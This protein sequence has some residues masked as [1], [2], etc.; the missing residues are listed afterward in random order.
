MKIDLHL[1]STA[2][3]GTLSPSALTWAARAGGLDVIALTDHDTCAGV[4]EALASLPANL[5]LVPGIELSTTV[6]ANELHILG[7]FIDH[8]NEA[9]VRHATKAAERRADR[10]RR[11]LELLKKYNIHL[12]FDDVLADTGSVRGVLGR[13]HVA[14]VLQRKGHVQTIGEAFDRFLG[15]G[16]PCFL[17]TELL[18][19]RDAIALIDAAG[20][21]SMW[22]HPRGDIFER[23]LPQLIEWGIRGLECIRP[24]LMPSEIQL[25]EETAKH[26]QLLISGGSDWHGIWHG[27]LG[28][29][30]VRPQEIHALLQVGGI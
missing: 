18:H 28:D 19:P 2:S 25:F 15:D 29:F 16:G 17:P 23:M 14:R 20:G 10:V 24:R 7:Y 30:F 1:H 27:R 13:P 22:A 26:H 11:M 3:D 21:V 4:D 6:D 5:H 8:K 12:T 9:L